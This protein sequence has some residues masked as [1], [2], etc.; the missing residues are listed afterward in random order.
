[1]KFVQIVYL[2][3]LATSTA[4][5]TPT[6]ARAPSHPHEITMCPSPSPCNPRPSPLCPIGSWSFDW[7]NLCWVCCSWN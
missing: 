3:I 5:S 6:R 7:G 4:A 2:T 1:M